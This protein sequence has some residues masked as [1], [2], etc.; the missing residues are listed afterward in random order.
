M[1]SGGTGGWVGRIVL[2][3]KSKRDG[4]DKGALI[5]VGASLI[6]MA[7]ATFYSGNG[8]AKFAKICDFR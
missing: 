3:R 8:A 2:G 4:L 1:C 6:G 7:V 5:V